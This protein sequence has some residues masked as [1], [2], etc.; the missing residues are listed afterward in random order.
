ME[1]TSAEAVVLLL[2]RICALS[3]TKLA[4]SFGTHKK[5]KEN[6]VTNTAGLAIKSFQTCHKISLGRL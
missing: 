1:G 3:R 2:G 4:I 6:F 5:N